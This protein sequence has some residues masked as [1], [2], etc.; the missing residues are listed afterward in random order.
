MHDSFKTILRG[1]TFFC[2]T[3]LIAITGYWWAGWSL[4]DAVYMTTI[5]IFGVGYGEVRPMNDPRLR[6]FTMFVI[7]AAAPPPRM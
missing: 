6:V 1:A 4:L 7:V 5:T 3:W 2:L